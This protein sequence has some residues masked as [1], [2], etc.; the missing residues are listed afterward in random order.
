LW[1]KILGIILSHPRKVIALHLLL[2]LAMLPGIF[3]LEMDNS[4]EVFFSGDERFLK[5]YRQYCREF[6]AGPSLRLIATGKSVWTAAG[7]A[8]LGQLEDKISV[9]PGVTTSV[10]LASF[11][12]W[13]SLEFPPI[14]P[15]SFRSRILNERESFFSGWVSPSG[16]GVSILIVLQEMPFK[17]QHAFLEQV[18][19]LSRPIPDGV[20]LE[21]SGIPVL[22][23]ALD[24]ALMR[25]AAILFP[26]LILITIAFLWFVFRTP[27]DVWIPIAFVIENQVILFG[28]MGHSGIHLNLVNIILAPLVFVVSLAGMIHILIGFQEYRE[29]GMNPGDAI[30]E[31]Y[32]DKK[33]P[34]LWTGMTTLAGFGSMITADL[35][36][37]RSLG[38]WSSVG[39][40][41]MIILDF[42]LYPALL[43]TA[44]AKRRAS[45]KKIP[46][47]KSG[48]RKLGKGLA[49]WSI[50][51][52]KLVLSV[53]MGTFAALIPGM[54][55]LRMENNLAG[56]LS[57]E[58]PVRIGLEKIQQKGLGVYA[59]ELVLSLPQATAQG[60]I[61]EDSGFF[62]P[63]AQRD[64]YRI[65]KQLRSQKG[66]LGGISSGDLVEAAIRS[67]IVEGEVTENVRWLTLGLLQTAPESRKFL[68]S[69]V[70][71]DGRRARISIL[72]PLANSRQLQPTFD[73][74][75]KQAE[76]RF[77]QAEIWLTGHL[78]MI[79]MAQKSLFKNMVQ[80]LS[81]TLLCVILVFYLHLG[82]LRLTSL[83][84]L[85]N[86]WPIAL[87]LGGMGWLSI[88]VDS[89][90]V[91]TAAI[92][93][94]LVVD[95]TLHTAHLYLSTARMGK[96]A[97]RIEDVLEKLAAAHVLTAIIL[98]SGFAACS[99][100]ELLPV[101][102]LGAMSALAIF[103]AL[104]GDL[105]MVPAL[106][107]L[108]RDNN[109]T[110]QKIRK[111]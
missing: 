79:M 14:D 85:P 55:F 49:R 62:N 69:L 3:Q 76:L 16:D 22:Q 46:D 73:L 68:R 108:D 78:P 63:S 88:A 21:V 105:L 4:P 39:I 27:A 13:Q 107:S 53:T 12:R 45:L 98:T 6:Q 31:T 103:F 36:L 109:E 30:R 41:S 42:V 87:V 89:A 7:L 94:G 56:Y 9:L 71:G 84:L 102:R 67:M 47:F 96:G 18:R 91:M 28:I 66:I 74:I 38:I 83:L 15:L 20:R 54:Y 60:S 19:R 81:L 1:L 104:V 25:M 32:R 43:I 10:G 110:R 40:V 58:H 90:S 99:I 92:I 26:V 80:A 35:P 86:L 5:E 111:A 29:M 100:S 101:A 64:L 75:R 34:L 2:A 82:N 59:V 97:V 37:L 24:H 95:N 51:H 8:W 11:C 61:D 93:L 48:A 77:P 23:Q 65:S 57:T 106:L 52:R 44:S 72:V 70:S 17:S 50:R 33:K